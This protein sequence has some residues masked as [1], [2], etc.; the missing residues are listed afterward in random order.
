MKKRRLWILGIVVI[1]FSSA[2]FYLSQAYPAKI[3]NLNPEVKISNNENVILLSGSNHEKNEGIIFYPGAKVEPYAYALLLEPFAL[4]GYEVVIAKMP[5][6]LAILKVDAADKIIAAHPHIT[7]W[8]LVGHSLGG[9]MAGK[10]LSQNPSKISSITFLASYTTES[11]K[12]YDGPVLS[13]RASQDNIL[14][15]DKYLQYYENLP[16]S[17]HEIIIEGGNHSQFGNYGQQKK[18]G[19]ATITDQ[20][21]KQQIQKAIQT[22][23]NP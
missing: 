11:L 18:D 6:N 14:D 1:L 23:L 20:E 12:D 19:Q 21:Q 2:T 8:H 5:F 7:K 15:Q 9:A 10:Y 13:I 17:T 22:L 4:Q 16:Q 3:D